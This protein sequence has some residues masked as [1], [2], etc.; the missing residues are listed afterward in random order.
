MMKKLT[1]PVG[2]AAEIAN[3]LL[4]A[5]LVDLA[6]ARYNDQTAFRDQL[7]SI[8]ESEIEE[9]DNPH[10]MDATTF[11]QLKF[12]T[13]ARLRLMVSIKSIRVPLPH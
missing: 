10:S 12:E 4:L 3:T 13:V 9:M 5:V 6:S 1:H 2:Q 7:M 8:L 11:A